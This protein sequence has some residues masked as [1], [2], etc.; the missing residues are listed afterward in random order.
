MSVWEWV[1]R[2]IVCRVASSNKRDCMVVVMA[3]YTQ[4]LVVSV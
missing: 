3:L 4:T 2:Y 1:R